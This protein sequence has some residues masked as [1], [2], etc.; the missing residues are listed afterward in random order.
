MELGAAEAL[1]AAYHTFCHAIARR[2]GDR[3]FAPEAKPKAILDAD[4]RHIYCR[5]VV[6]LLEIIFHIDNCSFGCPKSPTGITNKERHETYV[7]MSVF[8]EVSPNTF[9]GTGFKEHISRLTV[10]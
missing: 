2:A 1:V 6:L 5:S 4:L 3:L 7:L 8:I 9:V 10:C